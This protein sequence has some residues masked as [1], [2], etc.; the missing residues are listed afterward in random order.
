MTIE[1][2]LEDLNKKVDQMMDAFRAIHNVY[3]S[4]AKLFPNKYVKMYIDAC[5]EQFNKRLDEMEMK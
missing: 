2:E 3:E 5:V 1:K 4:T